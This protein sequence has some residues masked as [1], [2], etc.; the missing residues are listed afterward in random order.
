MLNQTVLN[1]QEH[2]VHIWENA[3]YKEGIMAIENYFLLDSF[4]EQL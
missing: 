2:V 3:G 1:K 4:I